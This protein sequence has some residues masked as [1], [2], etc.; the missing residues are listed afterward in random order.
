M[1]N[2]MCSF[3]TLIISGLILLGSESVLAEMTYTNPIIPADYSDPDVIRVGEDY[4]M[5][6]SS[7]NMVPGLPILH[8]KDL[9]NW[10]IIGHGVQELPDALYTTKKRKAKDLSYDLPRPGQGVFAPCI[11][12]HEGYFWIFWGDPDAGMYM[13]KAKNPEGPWSKP[14]LVKKAKGWIDTTPIWDE[15]TGRAWVA[16]AYARSRAGISSKVALVEMNWEGTKVISEDK[17][18][19]DADD[20]EKYPADKIHKTIEGCKFMKRNGFFY[21]LAPAGGVASGWQTALRSENPEG[22]YEIRVICERGNTNVNGPHQGGLFDTPN[23]EWWFIHF[24]SV[25][26]LGRI[27]HLQPSKWVD[28]WPVIGVDENNDGIGNP[29]LTY[30]VPNTG[31][32]GK[33]FKIQKSDDFEGKDIGLQWQWPANSGKGYCSQKNGSLTINS[34]LSPELTLQDAPNVITQMFPDF[35]FEAT[36]K[37]KLHSNENGVTRGGMAV[38]GRTCFDIGMESKSGKLILSVRHGNEL[39][40]AIE[41]QQNEVFLKLV[42][43]G[44]HPFP[45]KF[46][47]DENRGDVFCQFSYSLDGETYHP[48]GEKFKARAG[49][50]IG[51]RVGLFCL[52]TEQGQAQLNVD[53]FSIH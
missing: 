3:Y 44:E 53:H 16:H 17:I 5:T 49:A 9:I 36:T 15:E 19:F 2:Q 11:R 41:I 1:N 33:P 45:L 27:V 32:N 8:S 26:V 12:Y 37:V 43:N 51:A 28:N 40:A 29:V 6:A 38:M 13:V 24:Q 21:I 50:W 48:L 39:D 18:V 20:P 31:Y 4:Y 23:G 14:H 22:P 52:S 7:F 10:K 46:K 47:G 34:H 25:N 35:K 30:K 42:A